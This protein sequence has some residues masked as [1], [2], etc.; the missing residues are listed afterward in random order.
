LCLEKTDTGTIV[1]MGLVKGLSLIGEPAVETL[2]EALNDKDSEVRKWAA[3]ALN[4][5]RK[6]KS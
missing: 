2:I 5:I 6:K 1:L 4:K 3:K